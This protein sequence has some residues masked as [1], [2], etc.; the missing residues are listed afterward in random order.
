MSQNPFRD[1]LQN[2]YEAPVVYDAAGRAD[3]TAEQVRKA[4]ISH[5][6]S[7]KS[8]GVLYLLGGILLIVISMVIVVTS[9]GSG[10]ETVNLVAAVLGV[11]YLGLGSLQ[12]ATAFGLRKL[13]PWSRWISVVFSSIGLIGFP[14][15]T[16]I[17]AY[18]LYLLLS[19]KGTMVFSDE[20]KAIINATPHVK[21]KTSIVVWILLFILLAFIA[22][23]IG[24]ALLFGNR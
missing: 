2:P 23:A 14:I 7:I 4:H 9:V 1:P 22:L 5:E 24:S 17:S 13:A 6:A 19:Q 12:L 11:V 21:Y 16:L 8:I 20:Y 10:R 18:F 3:S 15:G